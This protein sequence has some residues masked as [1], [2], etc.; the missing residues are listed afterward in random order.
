[1]KLV[2]V[3]CGTMFHPAWINLD[4]V[5]LAPEVRAYDVRRGLPFADATVDMVYHSHVLEHLEPSAAEAFLGECFRVLRPGG[6]LRVVV[7]DLEQLARAYVA[8]LDSVA[9]V[10][11]L[12]HEWLRLELFDQFGRDRSGGRVGDFVRTLAPA[13]LDLVR[14][15]VGAEL[16]ALVAA[17]RAPARSVG[18]RVRSAGWRGVVRRAHHVVVRGL[19]RLFGGAAMARALEVGM[20]R[21]S[22]EVHRAAYDRFALTRLLGEMG[23]A[24]VRVVTAAESRLAGFVEFG[25]DGRDGGVRKPDSLFVE[26]TR[27]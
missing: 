8:L 23:F 22:G 3:G 16:D 12:V 15:R 9:P 26:A 4:V 21:A 11:P 20:F 24:D 6:V 13:Q 27:P 1:M 17:Q 10:N 7:P 18:A 25:L 2:N 5:P 19:V 14:A